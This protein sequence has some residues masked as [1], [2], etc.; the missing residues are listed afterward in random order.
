[1]KFDNSGIA[2][3]I[4]MQKRLIAIVAAIFIALTFFISGFY[5]FLHSITSLSKLYL[6]L[7]FS[8]FFIVFYVYHLV[9]ASS[10]IFFSDEGGKI[11]VRFYQLNLFNTSKN[12]FE[13]PKKEF[14]G[15][16]ILKRAYNIRE[17]LVL[18][19]KYQGKVVKYPPV[20]LNALPKNDKTKLIA[21]L[22][23]YSRES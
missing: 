10:Y 8:S 18:I 7:F 5:E 13:I 11:I 3:K 22:D 6:T 16:K 12:S 21:T 20:S 1:M 4:Q 2:I 23:K 14:L 17:E 19:R 9:A 15:Y